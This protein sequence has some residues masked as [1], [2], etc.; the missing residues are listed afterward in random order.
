MSDQN[1]GKELNINSL[2]SSSPGTGKNQNQNHSR[3]RNDDREHREYREKRRLKKRRP[4][5][6]RKKPSSLK[7]KTSV[8]Y[9][10]Y[11]D[12]DDDDKEMFDIL[13]NPRKKKAEREEEPE[14][15]ESEIVRSEKR[16]KNIPSL[17]RV[18]SLPK[19]MPSPIISAT[20]NSDRRR[21][22]DSGHGDF[23]AP[24]SRSPI[25]SPRHS[26]S[27][28]PLLDNP[29][30]HAPG[31]ATND[32]T[33]E[34][35]LT[36]EEEEARKQ[37]LLEG[38]DKLARKGVRIHRMFDMNSPL[39]EMESEYKRLTKQREI[40]NSIKFQRRLLMTFVTGVEML[41]KK[42]DPFDVELDGWSEV[43]MS[44]IESYD[45]IFEELYEKYHTKVKMAPELRLLFALGGSAVMFH[46]TNSM[47]KSGLPGMQANPQMMQNVA[48][49]M[50]SMGV[51]G[52]QRTA[53]RQP[54]GDDMKPPQ[55]PMRGPSQFNMRGP[56][57]SNAAFPSMG[58]GMNLNAGQQ[59]PPADF[60]PQQSEARPPR[61]TRISTKGPPPQLGKSRPARQSRNRDGPPRDDR[62]TMQGP[63]ERDELKDI[64]TGLQ[65]GEDEANAI[66]TDL[67]D[68]INGTSSSGDDEPEVKNVRLTQEQKTAG[69]ITLA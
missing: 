61:R 47:F 12:L 37:E 62:K 11:E 28:S 27:L 55:R 23:K 6:K 48:A 50:R 46:I 4:E 17:N 57:A 13:A 44:D 1:I 54:A 45:D 34:R 66:A 38:F 10:S 56:S 7:K 49:K 40:E 35:I 30:G 69:G 22:S 16:P 53:A 18:T 19:P 58:V 60:M 15:E 68:I 21:S 2:I 67:E 3:R 31:W 52:G 41:N 42:Y 8:R 36:P 63:N 33:F 64:L 5:E 51:N 26:S 65:L 32:P 43:V 14:E 9:E 25:V 24:Q 59:E 29:E 20:T 39:S